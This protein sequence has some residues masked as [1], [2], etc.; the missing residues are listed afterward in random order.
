[1]ISHMSVTIMGQCSKLSHLSL[2]LKFLN[3]A[4]LSL[5]PVS[6]WAAFAL[7]LVLLILVNYV[8][9]PKSKKIIPM[10]SGGLPLLGHT[11][12]FLRDAGKLCF[13]NKNKYGSLFALNIAGTRYNIMTD[14][15][16][17]MKR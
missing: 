2:Y 17:G 4:L 14:P 5:I 13:K 10:A 8:S 12:P 16:S 15:V 6:N 3:M 7:G 11:V 9:L 1:M